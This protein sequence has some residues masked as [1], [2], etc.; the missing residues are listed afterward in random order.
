MDVNTQSTIIMEIV[1]AHPNTKHLPEQHDQQSHA[2][3]ANVSFND[4]RRAGQ[5]GSVVAPRAIIQQF[6]QVEELDL[7]DTTREAIKAATNAMRS[8]WSRPLTDKT[9]DEFSNLLESVGTAITRIESDS[10]IKKHLPEQHNQKDHAGKAGPAGMVSHTEAQLL[11]AAARQHAKDTGTSIAEARKFLS[12]GNLL[13]RGGVSVS[14]IEY[15]DNL[16]GDELNAA[17]DLLSKYTKSD[18]DK[19][20]P[21]KHDQRTHASKTRNLAVTPVRNRTQLATMKVQMTTQL[22]QLSQT[23]LPASMKKKIAQALSDL[24]ALDATGDA[25]LSAKEKQVVGH[26]MN[27]IAELA[28]TAEGKIR[29][30]KPTKKPVK[31]K[32]AKPVATKPQAPTTTPAVAKP[33]VPAKITTPAVVTTPAA[34]TTTTATPAGGGWSDK[35]KNWLRTVGSNITGSMSNLQRS[36]AEHIA[37]IAGTIA[38]RKQTASAYKKWSSSL[39]KANRLNQQMRLEYNKSTNAKGIPSLRFY[40]LAKA[41]TQWQRQANK[42]ENEFKVTAGVLTKSWADTNPIPKIES[43]YQ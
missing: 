34:A 14:P 13:K 12:E 2:G 41:Y 32:A 25:P 26:V 17:I 7:E 8:W 16:E 19:H 3:A 20:L 21:E 15:F 22:R 42:F 36:A 38:S 24:K 10:A 33:A 30:Y 43:P 27:Q 31:P 11:D 6:K 5:N 40:Q 4:M 29:N 1:K 18:V 9:R 23:D 35:A 39:M 37:G 28:G